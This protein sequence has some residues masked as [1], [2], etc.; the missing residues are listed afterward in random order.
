MEPEF[1]GK[2]IEVTLYNQEKCKFS[3]NDM[4]LWLVL[5]EAVLS[6]YRMHIGDFVVLVEG[7]MSRSA[8]DIR[9]EA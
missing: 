1:L 4:A 3:T 7:N 8:K 9:R 2:I 6:E 5:E